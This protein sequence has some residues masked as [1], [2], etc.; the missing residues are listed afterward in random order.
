MFDEELEA[1]A[2]RC[3]C[4]HEV[5]YDEKGYIIREPKRFC[6]ECFSGRLNSATIPVNDLSELGEVMAFKNFRLMER[7][8]P[9]FEEYLHSITKKLRK[10]HPGYRLV[11]ARG[12]LDKGLKNW[13]ARQSDTQ[14]SH[15]WRV[16]KWGRRVPVNDRNNPVA[17][18]AL[19]L[20]KEHPYT[21]SDEILKRL[22]EDKKG[23]D[24]MIDEINAKARRNAAISALERR[25]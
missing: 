6:A 4:C 10:T 20:I 22:D 23:F 25:G 15:G 19:R 2:V 11:R 14:L 3:D 7:I 13:N 24:K 1:W 8:K 17:K 18:E 12:W 5:F 16:A 9:Y 21:L